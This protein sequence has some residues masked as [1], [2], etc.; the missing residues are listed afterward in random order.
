MSSTY[1]TA[2]FT[3]KTLKA[4]KFLSCFDEKAQ[5]I[6]L[7]DKESEDDEDYVTG[8]NANITFTIPE[9]FL[10]ALLH[11]KIQNTTFRT[12]V[13]FPPTAEISIFPNVYRSTKV[14]LSDAK[15]FTELPYLN[16]PKNYRYIIYNYQ[17]A[18][19]LI[20]NSVPIPTQFRKHLLKKDNDLVQHIPSPSDEEI[21]ELLSENP[22]LIK[23]FKERTKYHKQVVQQ[24]PYSLQYLTSP[25][26]EVV[27]TALSIDGTALR[28]LP[29]PTEDQ[30][31]TAVKQNYMVI[32]D[33]PKASRTKKIE[34]L[35]KNMLEAD[36]STSIP[37]S[38][39]C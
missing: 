4:K 38:S 13:G 15:P 25:S 1:A 31:L 34:A 6:C 36:K 14:Q 23:Y 12:I 30:I 17:A 26:E 37:F 5:F 11:A 18:L 32:K 20:K 19:Y 10:L 35:A 21:E 22:Y 29:A 27:Y 3:G 16:D 33:I 8:M 24:Q 2:K 28:F 9:N 7:T 39:I